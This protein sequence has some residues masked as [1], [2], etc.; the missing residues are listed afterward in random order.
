MARIRANNASGGGGGSTTLHDK[1]RLFVWTY[2]TTNHQLQFNDGTTQESAVNI[3]TGV[4][5]Y[6]ND[7]FEIKRVG[8]S[9]SVNDYIY[10]KKPGHVIN[11]YQTSSNV[12]TNI[13]VGINNF[14]SDYPK[15]FNAGEYF[16]D[17]VTN[18]ILNQKQI[19]VIFD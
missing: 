15:D 16:R 3:T 7:Y 14:T 18:G 2:S 12:P 19:E 5:S 10:F 8:S 4:F 9:S 11:C 17:S 13:A 6:E 1:P